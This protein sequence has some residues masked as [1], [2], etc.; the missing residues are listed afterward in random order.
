MLNRF[1][2]LILSL[3]SFSLVWGCSQLDI[4]GLLG[5][6]I[7]YQDNFQIV[8][9]VKD[10]PSNSQIKNENISWHLIGS[11]VSGNLK[12]GYI[13]L[14]N[15]KV[16]NYNINISGEGYI[17]SNISLVLNKSNYYYDDTYYFGHYYDYKTNH[18]YNE[19]DYQ[20]IFLF[21]KLSTLNITVYQDA[22]SGVAPYAELYISWVFSP[23]EDENS[24]LLEIL[25]ASQYYNQSQSHKYIADANGKI[26][27]TDIPGNTTISVSPYPFDS[28]SDGFVDYDDSYMENDNYP[29]QFNILPNKTLNLHFF[30]VEK[31]NSSVKVISTNIESGPKLSAPKAILEFNEPMDTSS[32]NITFKKKNRH[33]ADQPFVYSWVTSKKLEVT[34]LA[35]YLD[36]NSNY[37]LK[38]QLFDA[39]GQLLTLTY[40]KLDWKLTASNISTSNNTTNLEVTNLSLKPGE[41]YD[42]NKK[43]N[44]QLQWDPVENVKAYYVYAKD[45][46]KV[47][48]WVYLN[49]IT[50][51][52]SNGPIS[53]SLSLTNQFDRFA[54]DEIITPLMG[55]KVSFCVMPINS[56][57]PEPGGTHP[58]LNI[59][60]T[61]APKVTNF[62]LNTVSANRESLNT[63]GNLTFIIT[64]SEPINVWPEVFISDDNTA[65]S[66]NIV[67][68]PQNGEFYYFDTNRKII[69]FTILAPP[70]KNASG[71]IIK[72]DFSAVT[73]WTENL[74]KTINPG[75]GYSV[76][77]QTIT[78][79]I[80]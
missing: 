75:S 25:F 11:E 1:K 7:N 76:S 58:T 68:N 22:Y 19:F 78:A 41:S 18:E 48:S 9:K 59:T 61:V 62:Q 70:K 72:F 6:A 37:F 44:Y 47:N 31:P 24:S 52:F 29:R 14:S 43:N 17:T 12:E 49:K 71:D 26:T 79:T 77:N 23:A 15:L 74:V 55:I 28:N 66:K 45:N 30:L 40:K 10:Y 53:A 60:D 56:A 73:D 57:N 5:T 35:S 64:L 42:F 32:A 34:P 51:D 39:S 67:L 50:A 20:E 46:Y 13:K 27:I 54:D 3:V 2:Y 4:A 69:C 16:G 8:F 36:E 38:F 33:G 65:S 63:T 80:K 21:P